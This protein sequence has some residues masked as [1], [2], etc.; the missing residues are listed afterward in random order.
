LKQTQWYFDCIA[1]YSS[2]IKSGAS[3]APLSVCIVLILFGS[4]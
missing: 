3:K 1:E 2:K 4:H